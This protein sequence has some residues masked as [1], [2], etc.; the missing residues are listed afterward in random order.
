MLASLMGLGLFLAG[1]TAQ[2]Q[3][4]APANSP[5]GSW[6]TGSWKDSSTDTTSNTNW[7]SANP[8]PY[9]MAPAPVYTPTPQKDV[10]TPALIP[11]EKGATA[12]KPTPPPK[13]GVQPVRYQAPARGYASQAAD[14]LFSI[15]I[16]LDNLPGREQ[17]FRLES[18]TALNE[19]MRQEGLTKPSRERIT[20]PDEPVVSTDP[21]PG[22]HWPPMP[23]YAEPSYVC[24]GRLLFEQKST[25]RYGWDLGIIQP[26]VST[27]AFLADMAI[28]PY[29]IAMSPCRCYECSAG[30]CLPGDPVPYLIYPIELSA[31]GGI[32]EA[33]VV[34]GLLAIFP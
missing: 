2:A 28:L 34:L 22:R 27:G 23:E 31:T 16:Q 3:N 13:Y 6:R 7:K 19:R 10:A 21:Y 11:V 25:E 29:Q 33:G 30:Q 18:E 14:D 8:A 12:A 9:P 4:W 32:A 15:S 20:F 26:V 17:L 5:Y 24:Y 1:G